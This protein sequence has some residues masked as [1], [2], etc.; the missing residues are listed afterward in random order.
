ME[1]K[2]ESLKFKNAQLK[3]VIKNKEAELA[4]LRLTLKKTQDELKAWDKVIHQALKPMVA[5]FMEPSE[6]TNNGSTI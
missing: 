2:V 4:S 6:E 3:E 5:K 1:D